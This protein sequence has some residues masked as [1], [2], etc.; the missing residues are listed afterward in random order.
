MKNRIKQI[1]RN[2]NMSQTSFGKSL[3]VS[4]DVISNY[5][6][7]RVEPTDLFINHLCSTFHINENWLRTGTGEMYIKSKET[8]LDELV[9]IHGLND[10]ET[11][12]IKAFLQLSPEGRAG[13]LEYADNLAKLNERIHA[14]L[15]DIQ[16]SF[17][18][19]RS[20]SNT[21]PAIIDSNTE[22]A[23][24]LHNAPKLSSDD[25]L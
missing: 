2:Q 20:D 17:R 18:A 15:S 16:Y 5:E 21:E 19:A 11:A 12:V 10:R 7:G 9:L 6:M 8:I 24:G 13:V 23:I 3:G 25:E 4:R 1:R 22:R 14:Q